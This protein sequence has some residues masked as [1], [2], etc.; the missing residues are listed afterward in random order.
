MK[1]NSK[2][3]P[4]VL[5]AYIISFLCGFSAYGFF[6]RFNDPIYTIDGI[7]YML[8]AEARSNSWHQYRWTGA[9]VVSNTNEMATYSGTVKIPEKVVID[10]TE[11]LVYGFDKLTE[12]TE[13]ISGDLVIELP[14]SIKVIGLEDNPTPPIM[15][16]KSFNIPNGVEYID[17][18]AYRKPG[19]LVIP[20]SVKKIGYQAFVYADDLVLEDGVG[21]CS[22]Y[23]LGCNNAV[24]AIPGTIKLGA[25]SLDAVN[26]KHLIIKK[27]ANK[28]ASPEFG[29]GF[30]DNSY[31]IM[32]ITCEYENPPKAHKDAFRL[33]SSNFDPLFPNDNPDDPHGYDY[34]PTMYDRAT[35]YVPKNAIEAYKTDDVW[36]Q[37]ER[38]RAIE[39]GI[40]D[41]PFL[42]L[43]T[44]TVGNLR[45]AVNETVRDSYHA[46]IYKYTGAIV[47]PNN[48]ESVKYS[49]KITVPE[50][51][52]INGTEYPVFGF[53]WLSEYPENESSDLEIS[54]P[55]GLKVIG[56]NRNFGG[57]HNTIK[58]INIP[59]TVEYIGAMKYVVPGATMTLP[60]TIKVVSAAAGIEAEKLII[61]DGVQYIGTHLAEKKLIRC[62]N[63]ELTIP[64][65]VQFGSRA[66]ETPKLESIKI[67]KSKIDGAT[68]YLGSGFCWNTTSVKRITCEYD[69]PPETS[70]SAF[71]DY[72]YDRATLYVP[73]EAI[74]AYKAAPEWKN[75]KNI[76]PIKDGVSDVAADDAQVVATEYHDLAG[77]RLEAPAERS[78]TIRTDIYSDG[79]RRCTKILH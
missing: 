6:N 45:Y 42:G 52:T 13:N 4:A 29:D 39:D 53:M 59:K 26:L 40:E 24:L 64:G 71:E 70:G 72:M 21:Q 67:T 19:T 33:E 44:Y 31:D 23:S 69:V 51:V 38:I 68:P 2:K 25:S 20:G 54:L 36:G 58:A 22:A 76:L 73:E 37:F 1:N 50:K 66:I 35:L 30:C 61:E 16:I 57:S 60:G 8:N 47:I 65:S 55:E 77:R 18:L 3:C 12:H 28:D 48:D 56:F 74:E 27:S 10:G 7:S 41:R 17:G 62:N 46:S 43:P 63:T 11:Y 79:T 78:I 9:V 14:N 5:L 15:N 34:H 49:G 75:F 32:A